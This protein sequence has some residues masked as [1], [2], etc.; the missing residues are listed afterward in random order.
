MGQQWNFQGKTGEDYPDS[1]LAG[2]GYISCISP[3]ASGHRATCSS[4]E[5]SLVE[6]EVQGRRWMQ[7]WLMVEGIVAL[8]SDMLRGCEEE[9]HNG[10]DSLMDERS[11]EKCL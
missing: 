8:S 1:W 6:E 9:E 11:R 2:S 10:K 3:T 4:R 7:T 5:C